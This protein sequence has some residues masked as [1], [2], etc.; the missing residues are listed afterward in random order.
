MEYTNAETGLKLKKGNGIEGT[1]ANDTGRDN[2]THPLGLQGHESLQ[3]E[4]SRPGF[5]TQILQAFLAG[6]DL[7]FDEPYQKRSARVGIE[8][9]IDLD[10]R[11]SLERLRQ[12]RG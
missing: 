3:G 11:V 6:S 9:A 1:R 4:R 2:K 5:R 12:A 7:P 8:L 10:I